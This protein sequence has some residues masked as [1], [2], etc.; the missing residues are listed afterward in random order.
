MTN[1]WYIQIF[2]T[3]KNKKQ[4]EIYN[5][6][7][8]RTIEKQEIGINFYGCIPVLDD[9][10]KL[11]KLDFTDIGLETFNE[12]QKKY[13]N[14]IFTYFINNMKEDDTIYLKNGSKILYKAKI[15]CDYILDESNYKYLHTQNLTEEDFNT[16]KNDNWFWRH[17]RK[18]KD[19]EKIY[20]IKP[21]YSRQTLYCKKL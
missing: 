21:G 2:S 7:E 1:E 9:N 5:I 15:A 10:N 18:I 19:I 3:G 11:L 14:K 13:K 12:R 16:I 8:N 20:E 6:I 4:K 17:R